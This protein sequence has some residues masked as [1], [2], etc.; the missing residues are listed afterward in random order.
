MSILPLRSLKTLPNWLFEA[1]LK[2]ITVLRG[3]KLSQMFQNRKSQHHNYPVITGL[4]EKVQRT[5]EA[6]SDAPGLFPHNELAEFVTPKN[7]AAVL[8][9]AG[10]NDNAESLAKYA[11]EDAKKLFLILVMMTD[12]EEKLSLLVDLQ[13]SKITDKSLPVQFVKEK[14]GDSLKWYLKGGGDE[15]NIVLNC[16]WS[17]NDRALLEVYQCYF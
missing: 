9:E 15:K 17:R 14:E 16:N 2:A 10:L 11:L 1:K 6:N 12:E 8:K 3:N 13:R 5:Q 7:V 4:A